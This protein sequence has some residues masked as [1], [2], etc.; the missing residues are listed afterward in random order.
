[1]IGH[2]SGAYSAR[3]SRDL[4]LSSRFEF[5]VYSF[6]SKWDMG[7]EWWLRRP[8]FVPGYDP[9]SDEAPE[10]VAP[11]P[12]AHFPEMVHGVVKAR[13]S[14]NNVRHRPLYRACPHFLSVQDVSLM[15]EG[16]LRNMLISLGVVSDF[17]NRSKPIKAI[18]LELS[19]FS[20]G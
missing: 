5:N 1:M 13:A 18:G 4:S 15:W 17:S 16:R 9:S 11:S 3:V 6:E 20:S 19:Y 7:A 12:D 2:L 8:A 14:T 10:V